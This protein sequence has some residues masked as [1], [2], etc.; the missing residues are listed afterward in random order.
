L[1]R[2]LDGKFDT[3]VAHACHDRSYEAGEQAMLTRLCGAFII[4]CLGLGGSARA[5]QV[6][7]GEA[8]FTEY[9]ATQLRRATGSNVEVKGP[10][11]LAVGELQAN[12]DRIFAYCDRNSSG[13][14]SEV[15]NYVKG[16]AQVHKDRSAPPSKEA[17]RVVVRTVEYVAA[18][19]GAMTKAYVA[20]EHGSMPKEAPPPKLQ[21]RPL[22]GNLVMLPAID[23]P[24][25]IRMLDEKDNQ[26][27][28]LSPDDVFDLGFVNLR[29]HLKPLMSVAKVAKAGQFGQLSGD[30]Y[31]SSR[32]AL[33]ESWS[34]LVKAHGGK[35]IVTAPTTDAV[36]YSGD[37]SSRAI[38]ALRLLAK[39]VSTRVPNPLSSELLRWTPAGWKVVR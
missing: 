29:Q 27:L 16:V 15:S 6:P 30:A 12:L 35:L 5:Q 3:I 10:L 20:S 25:T 9:V 24:R 8:A 33:L 34:P 19:Q 32:L 4:V 37:D 1:K 22:A 38:E 23:M 31:H 18:A 14:A 13:C 39:N 36:L 26:A 11:T 17:V 2:G 28:G 7:K 21:P